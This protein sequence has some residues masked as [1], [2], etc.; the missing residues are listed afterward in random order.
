MRQVR[1]LPLLALL[2]SAALVPLAAQQPDSL[3]IAGMRWRN[4]GPANHQGRVTDV[5]GIPW[6]S[7]TFYVASAGGGVW[8]STNAGTTFRPVFEN[9]HVSSGGMLAISPSDTNTVYYG[10]GE[11]NTRNSISPGAGVYK[12]TNGG[13][14]WEFIGL[15]E[16]E[17][18]GR[19]VVH[20]RDPN[21]VYVAALGHAWG[22]NKERGLYK[23]TDGGKTWA[24]KKFI[25]DKAGFVDVALDPRDPN[26]V[27][28]SSYERVR[29]PY[30]LQSGGP[31]SALWKSA[32]AGETWA[33]VKGNGFPETMKGRI[34]IA[35]AAS[36][37][38]VMYTQVEADTTAN[39]KKDPKVKA[40]KSPTGLYRSDDAGKTWT[41]A[42]DEDTRPFYYSQVRVDPTNPNHVFWSSTP[43]KFSLD[44]GKT[45]GNTTNNVHVDHHAMWIDPKDP[46]HI[47]VG[48][49]GGVAQTWD[50]GGNWD[51]MNQLPIGQYYNVSFDMAVPYNVCGGA[52]DNGAW[53]G[54]SRRRT[55]TITNS[56]WFTFNGGDGFVTAQDPANPDIIYGESQGGNIGRYTVS[57]GER[58]GLAKPQWRPKYTQWED[59]IAVQWPDT[60][61]PLSKDEKKRVD[62]FRAAQRRDSIDLD[63]RWNW[64]TP[65]MISKHN[66][67]V[68]YF[69]ANRVLKSTKMGDE[70]YPISPDL[71]YADTMKIRVSTQTTGGITTDATGAETFA[72]VVSLNESP[73]RPGILFAGTDDGRLW[74]TW[75]DGGSWNDLSKNVTT[76]PAGTYVSRIEPS[77]FDSLTFYVTF[78][79]HRRDDFTPYVL[80][81]NDGGKTFRSIA[82]NLPTGGPDFAYVIREDLKNQNL[83][84][85]GTDVGAY[86]SMNKGQSWQ[87][88]MTG[89]PTTPVMD[90]LIHPR[91]GEL[92]AATHGRG[93][94][95][96][97]IT[98]LQ[99]W[100]AQIADKAVH[101]FAPK[102]AF[103]WGERAFDGQSVGQKL[104]EA[105]SPTYGAEIVYRVTQPVT[106]QVKV[107]VQDARGD[108]LAT[109]N[110]PGRAGI[111]RVVWNYRGKAPPSIALSPAGVR[112]SIINARKLAT[113]L[114][115]VEKEGTLP[116]S[117]VDRIRAV[118]AS[119][120]GI[121][122]LFPGGFG[123]G[124]GGGFGRG[125]FQERPGENMTPA[126]GARGAGA[127]GGRGAVVPAG[128]VPAGAVPAGAAA[129]GAPGAEAPL[130]AQAIFTALGGGGRG[131]A[132]ALIFGGGG[133][134][135]GPPPVVGTG[136]YLV[137]I[138]IN[139][140]TQKQLLH[141]ERASGTGGGGGGFE[142]LPRKIKK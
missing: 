72:N 65:F 126:A 25:S 61:K 3:T 69:G 76:V 118:M 82:S 120:E 92:V 103:Q 48:D 62:G 16:T 14:S 85:V 49:D 122:A 89:L 115:S 87:R 13:K 5:Q 127:G 123:G 43:I 36:D 42:N 114:D 121:Q 31:G 63:M 46:S 132:L 10:T 20:P 59:S 47:I 8:K 27:W 97:D 104:F 57:T 44:G 66:P 128:A 83:L 130:D 80:A 116:K 88:F 54:P 9:E 134:R 38:N 93:F 113:L 21:I 81:T 98:P 41:K 137:S 12:T 109:L 111:Q 64:N 33:E 100:T 117:T 7:R 138:T 17:Q 133:G 140:Q 26:V 29:G 73:I 106:G 77:H 79:N 107:I 101:L 51:S 32:D 86:V 78:D 112:D 28:A 142:D 96:A 75:N 67:Q 2:A 99:Q 110:G 37:P 35:I 1:T 40:Q 39:P 135:G 60:T 139:G 58:F 53:C 141:V 129:G 22:A 102:T 124:G 136:D 19:I 50:S 24:L 23:S 131:S 6:P 84:F 108:T 70:M 95:I 105:Q 90:L 74:V 68:L 56:M 52:Q 15:K 119:G 18:I 125:G 94:W 91:D 55:G 34:S 11:P 45:T 71:S 30:F 4:I